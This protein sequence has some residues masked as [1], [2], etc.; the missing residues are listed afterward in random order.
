MYS[1]D[2]PL[3]ISILHLHFYKENKE[4]CSLFAILSP[5]TKGRKLVFPALWGVWI[6]NPHRGDQGTAG[7]VRVLPLADKMAGRHSAV[8]LLSLG[9]CLTFQSI[10]S[11]CVLI[12]KLEIWG[13]RKTRMLGLPTLQG[14]GYLVLCH[15]YI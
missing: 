11:P 5:F 10:L 3:C 13:H 9:I 6:Y 12:F 7:A 2:L 1:H 8:T 14:F 4:L 15:L